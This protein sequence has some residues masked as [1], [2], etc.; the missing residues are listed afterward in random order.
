MQCL[1]QLNFSG[2][3]MCLHCC[4][5]SLNTSMKKQN[6]KVTPWSVPEI[7]HNDNGFSFFA[8]SW[9]G[10]WARDWTPSQFR[11]PKRSP[12][13]WEAHKRADLPGMLRTVVTTRSLELNVFCQ[14][15]KLPQCF[16]ERRRMKN[17]ITQSFMTVGSSRDRRNTSL[18]LPSSC[19]TQCD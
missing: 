10:E 14:C 6:G 17:C 13:I 4:W 1:L 8:G 5:C 7:R 11:C 19:L 9:A 15:H 12:Q 2:L 18:G 16:G 3:C